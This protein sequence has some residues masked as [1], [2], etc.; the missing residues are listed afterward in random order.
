MTTVY[1]G[2]VYPT[3][4][5]SFTPNL[6][7]TVDE[8]IADHPN[9][10]L[11]A[12]ELIEAKLG[13][14]ND[15]A[16]GL[17]GVS[18]DVLGQAANPG[19]AGEPTIWVDSSGGPGF[20]LKY[21]DDLAVNYD[22]LVS[23]TS[24]VSLDIAYDHGGSG[25]GRS[26]TADSGPVEI[27][28]PDTTN[29]VGLKVVNNDDTNDP[30][31][32][33][34]E[35]NT[36]AGSSLEF[37]G[38]G[39]A[40][41]SANNAITLN[42]SGGVISIG[43]DAVAQAI[44]VGTGA[45]ARTITLGNTSGATSL[46]F[47]TGTGDFDVN[48]GGII[49]LDSVGALSL[50]SS[51][52]QIHIGNDA[53]A[54]DI[55][56]GR[57]AAARTI[58]I[59]NATGATAL[60]LQSGTG[61]I[62]IHDGVG[63]IDLDGTG[64]LSTTGIDKIDLDCS[65]SLKINSSGSYIGIGDDA[66]A[67]DIYIGTGAAAR[68]ITLGNTSGATSLVFNTGTGSFDVNAGGIIDLD[69][70][71]A[72]SLNSSGGAINIGNDAVAQAI[73]IGTGAAARTLIIGNSTG[74]TA[75]VLQSGSG[76]IIFNDGLGQIDFDGAGNLSTSSVGTI[77][78][79]CSGALQINSSGGIISIGNDAVA[80]AIN[81]GTGAAARNILIGNSTTT[82]G[83]ALLTGT[84]GLGGSSTGDIVFDG[85]TG[86]KINSTGGALEIG[87]NANAQAINIGTGAAART[88]TIGNTTGATSLVFNTGTG[89][90]DVN[91][92]GIIDLDSVGAL[93]LNSSGGVINIGD[94]AVAQNI[95]VGTGAAAR[96]ITIGNATGAT[97]L[98][99]DSGSGGI[100][101][102]S[103][104]VLTLSGTTAC[105]LSGS[106][107]SINTSAGTIDIGS[108]A[109]AQSVNLGTGAGA[110]AVTVG[111]LTGAAS[112]SLKA[113]TGLMA[114]ADGYKAG[115]TYSTDLVLS[116][117]S[118]EWDSFESLY[119]E[120]SILNAINQSASA[121]VVE[122]AEVGTAT[123]DSVQDFINNTQS[124]LYVDGGDFTEN[125]GTPGTLDVS[126]VK[127]YIK[128]TDSDI[129]DLVAFDA[130]AVSAQ[131]L[132][133]GVNY[134]YVEYNGGSPQIVVTAVERTDHN[135]NVPLGYAYKVP[136][137]TILQLLKNGHSYANFNH[138]V[139]QYVTSVFGTQRATG[140]VTTE[141]GSE[142]RALNI[143]SGIAYYGISDYDIPSIDTSASHAIF[144]VTANNT[145]KLAGGLGD[146][147]GDYTQDNFITIEGSVS[148]DGT[149]TVQSVS[150]DGSNTIVVTQETTLSPADDTGDVY[151]DTLRV[152]YY[153]GAAW[154]PTTSR[155]INNTQYNNIASGLATLS[156]N[157]YGVHWVFQTFPGRPVVVFGQDDYTLTE[158]QN[159]QVPSLLPDS[160][161]D[162]SVLIAKIIIEKN[163]ANFTEIQIPYGEQWTSTVS[164]NHN[165]LGGLQGGTTDEYYH[166]TN[167]E[168][169]NLTHSAVGFGGNISTSST[170]LQDVF[171][172]YDREAAEREWDGS[173]VNS[174]HKI[175]STRGQAQDTFSTSIFGS[176][177]TS[178]TCNLTPDGTSGTELDLATDAVYF[179]VGWV[180]A[181][182]A[183]MTSG[184]PLVKS[185]EIK[186]TVINDNGT[187]RWIGVDVDE[188]HSTN[189]GNESDWDVYLYLNQTDEELEIKGTSSTSVGSG[190]TLA[191]Q[192]GL[193][194]Q[195]L[196]TSLLV[197]P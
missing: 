120:V 5:D 28:I 163:D 58:I 24:Y 184:T 34:V 8:V 125:V 90:F 159:A 65:G 82:S 44:N 49:D 115:S 108:N 146:V 165:D 50:N 79:D 6:V 158:A 123:Y 52:G 99:L 150:W 39:T 67:Q 53:V 149:Y 35:N 18:F 86:V 100:I 174:S 176:F 170:L 129:G 161:G 139:E 155:I 20:G 63:R 95:N 153:N 128:T 84:N 93:S 131:A 66:V 75:I 85:A 167:S 61:G 111:S 46:V 162:F 143:T 22:I 107:V 11:S 43:D 60:G 138:Q 77:D 69:S 133:D 59:G 180:V 36:S 16:V 73:N 13:I 71:G 130:S 190:Y 117:A 182:R 89:S 80:Q 189:N 62:I 7:D 78:L 48:A 112:L 196:D 119:G 56:I 110:K 55:G 57:G 94:D 17:G 87:N 42:S 186:F 175:A 76:G 134:V 21:T 27:T 64:D 102:T 74:A 96:V 122:V 41:I 31:A 1:G 40:K 37:S 187:L 88:V 192:G 132:S 2:S 126:A 166:L 147:T 25:L 177:V 118:A 91:A 197:G 137:T 114:F 9:T 141:D 29:D 142:D 172:E 121:S 23:G 101:L 68:T 181:S 171:D 109:L 98:A 4:Y 32:L 103:G 160:L 195:K 106:S 191:F 173:F 164:S 26:I 156:N 116:D 51:G 104:G 135:T 83:I 12:I 152:F 157:K 136:T 81:I 194:V 113:G 124:T 193:R 169:T 14:D 183:D 127:G 10:A 15:P 70:V 168:Y 45:A 33:E 54:Q 19:G 154:I 30:S 140:L 3:S 97:G 47:N 92:G 151:Y 188:V 185:W 38:T 148:N 144:D 145:I 178:G 179:G 72:L 105:T